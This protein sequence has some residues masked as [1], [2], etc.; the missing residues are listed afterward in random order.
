MMGS[1]TGVKSPANMRSVPTTATS[2]VLHKFELITGVTSE[3]SLGI[4][5]KEAN[6]DL[7][8]AREGTGMSFKALLEDVAEPVPA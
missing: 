5:L 2:L 7:E 6:E 8:E 3:L 1:I 4:E